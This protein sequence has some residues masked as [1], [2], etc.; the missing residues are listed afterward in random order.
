MLKSY[1][2]IAWRN[3]IRN[4]MF[5][6]INIAGLSIGV[7]CCMLILLYTKDEVS[8]DKFHEN[9]DQLYQLVVN[10][11]ERDGRV[12]NYAASAQVHGPAFAAEIPEIEEFVR[13]QERD[14]ILKKGTETLYERVAFVEPNFFEV[15]SF[16]LME[17]NAQSVL[18]DM[19]SVVITEEMAEKYFGT[20]QAVGKTLEIEI[21]HVFEP[22][23]VSGI[24]KNAP[25]NSSIQF[26]F[27]IPFTYMEKKNPDDIWLNISYPTYLVLNSKAD[28]KHVEDQMARVFEAK[29]GQQIIEERKH[30]FDAEFKFGVEPLT[31]LHLNTDYQY[32]PQGSNPVYS[33][34][35]SGLALFILIIACINFVN[36]TVA[37]SLRRGREI[38]IRKVIGGERKELLVQFLGEA[39]L[40]SLLAFSLAFVLTEL[41][42]P[43]FNELS[44]KRLSLTYLFDF[45]LI[46]GFLVLFL[47][48]ILAAGF[49][50]A[51]ILS[52]FKPIAALNNRLK[53]TGRGYLSKGLVVFQFAITTFMVITSIFVYRQ[54]EFLTQAD[55]G[56]NDK[57]LLVVSVGRDDDEAFQERYKAEFEKIAGVQSVAQRQNGF[58]VT[59]S[60]VNGKDIEVTLEHVDEDYLNTLE[61]P[62]A[63]GRNFSKEFAGD[64]TG[65]VLVNEAYVKAAGWT[66]GGVGKSID[67]FNGSDNKL[68]V[69]GVVKNYVFGDLRSD[70][71]P[72]LFHMQPGGLRGRFFL[73]IEPKS[74]ARI[75]SEVEKIYRNLSPYRPFRYDFMKDLND[76]K[77]ESEAKWRQIIS[78]GAILMILV[79]CMGLLG[80]SMLSVQQR[81][82]EIGIRK[83]L[84]AGIFE[85]LTSLSQN[86]V[87][88]ILLSMLFAIPA[89][90][91]AV[92]RWLENFAYSVPVSGWV[93][94]IGS[95]L[96]IGISAIIISSQALKGA[97][98][99]PVKSLK[100]E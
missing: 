30:G 75:I 48:T 6:V 67:F 82:K 87:I 22:F 4:K 14:F 13:F 66:D 61:I 98:I 68:T 78:F 7:A 12:M 31:G 46:A 55:L 86:F 73:R 70:I 100:S 85:I 80:L 74:R 92:S 29:A 49:Y 79:S 77:Y 45:Q 65:S 35:L 1:L 57:N 53:L 37:H 72:Q 18:S 71:T 44:N 33:Y 43:V 3:L 41:S 69:V 42:L 21:D 60:K 9:K 50:P 11:T 97:T 63:A 15:F 40:L 52:G 62:L 88:L 23:T 2:K 8:F 94:L 76:Q 93:F 58:W 24:A 84:G 26:G 16:P 54:F 17:G 34:I 28:V 56:Y 10:V 90:Y 64:A 83:V 38:G 95:F 5:S 36:L 59:G 47:L 19:R 81:F 32:I 25:Q 51:M 39:A 20:T 89:A 27:L 96:V 91:Y 99:D